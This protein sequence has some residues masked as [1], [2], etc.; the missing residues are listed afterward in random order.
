M[1]EGYS[2][3][4]ISFSPSLIVLLRRVYLKIVSR[5]PF[6]LSGSFKIPKLEITIFI[7]NDT[8]VRAQAHT[9]FDKN[10]K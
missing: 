4:Y 1:W 2:V 6:R 5:F 7:M 9:G 8:D 3:A 10:S